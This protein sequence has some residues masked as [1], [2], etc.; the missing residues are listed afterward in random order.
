[1]S[2][3]KQPQGSPWIKSLAIWAAIIMVMLV[4]ASVVSQGNAAPS[5]SLAYSDFR[6][7]VSAGQVK[8]VEI[9]ESRITGELTNGDKFA[10]NPIRDPELTKLLSDRGV[11]FDGK[12]AEQQNVWAYI[13]INMLPF[14]LLLGLGFFIFRQVQKN[15]G[16]GAMGF[17]KSKAKL[18]TE[19]AG[20]VTFDDVAMTTVDEKGV[21]GTYTFDAKT[22]K[23]CSKNPSGEYCLTF[24]SAGLAKPGDSVAFT[25]ADGKAGTATLVSSQ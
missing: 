16:G 21:K 5:K 17:G 8:S 14:I 12:P 13:L 9:G 4:I 24:A 2:D 25:T 7:K 18:L 1:M 15:N 22:L 6:S 10:T 20:R 23:L 3:D 11:T 19:K